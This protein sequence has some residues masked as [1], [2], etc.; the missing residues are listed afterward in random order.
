MDME[1][2]VTKHVIMRGFLKDISALA[3]STI[4]RAAA[5][6]ISELINKLTGVINMHLASEDSFVYPKLLEH[7]DNAIKT[8]T[9][10]YMNEMCGIAAR[11]TEFHTKYKTPSKILADVEGFKTAF[12]MIRDAFILRMDREEKELYTFLTEK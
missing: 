2:Y 5:M 1:L 4:D 3:D 9:H 6:R 11:Y 7:P 12:K 10:A 8:I